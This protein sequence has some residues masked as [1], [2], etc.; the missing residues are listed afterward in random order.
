MQNK[1]KYETKKL[2][3]FIAL[4]LVLSAF[5]SAEAAAQQSFHNGL[6]LQGYTGVL[7]TPSA[8]VTDEGWLYALYTNQEESKWREKTPFQDNYLFSVGL[9][10]FIE[11]G[12]RLFEAPGA[13]RDLSANVKVTTAPLTRNYPL[14]PV[15]AAGVQDVSGGAAFLQSSYLVVSEDIWRLRL[16]AGYGHGPD[17]MKGLFAGAE[18]K[19]HDWVYLLGEYDTKDTNIGARV[20]LPQFWKVPVSFTATAKTSLDYKPGNFDIAVGMSMPL[21]FKIRNKERGEKNQESGTRYQVQDTN[22][23]P[24]VNP[25][26]FVETSN[27]Q[28]FRERLIRTGFMNVRV[29][30]FENRMVVVEY[31]NS[32]FNHNELDAVGVIAGMATE[33]LQAPFDRLRLV[34]M[35]KGIAMLQLTMPLSQAAAFME[36]EHELDYFKDSLDVSYNY[37]DTD[38]TFISGDKNSSQLSTSLVISPGLSTWVGT[39]VGVFDYLLSLKADLFVQAWKGGVVNARWNTPLSW[40]ENLDDGKPYRNSRTGTRMER[41]MLFQGI[42]LLPNVMANLGAGM[43]QSDQYGTMNEVVWQP[44]RGNHLVRMS[45]LW[46]HNDKDHKNIE[47][48]LGSYRYYFSPL[49]LS[50]EGVVG[51]FMSQD[52]GFSLE[53]K[54]FFGDTALSVYYKN[55][56][57]PDGVKRWEKDPTR[58]QAVGV[59]LSFPLTPGKDMK[60]YGKMQVRGTD[61]WSYTQ[62]TTSASGNSANAN[63]VPPVQLAAVPLFTGS[64]HNQYLNRDRLSE[65]YILSHLDRLREAWLRYKDKLQ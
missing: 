42:K 27:L 63:Y 5:Y 30:E 2:K 46:G 1:L 38:V 53:L 48:F 49:D 9:F 33:S 60:H 10:N 12:G 8:H 21:D 24:V 52:R 54:R 25:K 32:I 50:L 62:E 23:E 39:E 61:E 57:I 59:Q 31:E 28:L 18:F 3:L 55:T 34:I 35:K 13:G 51:K 45:Q 41:L 40:S 20:V 22:H 16:S 58:W 56:S 17:R 15:I 19:A 29:G 65:V 47:S 44:G 64:L 36:D 14:V 43:L 37:D 6:S 7:N 4:V 11:L 26:P